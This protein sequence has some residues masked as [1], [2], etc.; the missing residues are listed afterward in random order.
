MNEP[1][2]PTLPA[3]R[4][5]RPLAGFAPAFRWGLRLTC[6]WRRMLLV[7]GL[8]TGLALLLG[9][10][11]VGRP[12]RN[13]P[14]DAWYDLWL[15]VDGAL[16]YYLLPIISLVLVARGFSS[17]VSHQTLVYHLVRPISR[18]TLFVARFG[19]GVVPAALLSTAALG[20]CFLGSGLPVPLGVWL[21]LP[22][23]ALVGTLAVGAFYYA[24]S[25][26]FRHG[27]IVALIYTFVV[28]PLFSSQRGA[29][30]KLSIMFHVRGMHHG[31]TDDVFR[32]QSEHV[33]LALQP[34]LAGM[35]GIDWRILDNLMEVREKIAYD[36]PFTA[37]LTA[38][39][40]A[41][42]LLGFAAWRIGRRD[43]ALKE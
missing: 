4:A 1:A 38:V 39:G 2:R 18:R 12:H 17:E 35:D 30:Q 27:T 19:S 31:L 41:V 37:L 43:F 15:L 29:M 28:E 11:D 3:R 34:G 14:L 33:R 22:A 25:A 7:G 9:W 24:V 23:T 21:A 32:E 13:R 10:W 16:L 20:A 42:A 26:L 8:A 40:V 36:E 6:G 5:Y